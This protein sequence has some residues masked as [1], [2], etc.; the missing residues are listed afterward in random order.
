MS[1]VSSLEEMN[2]VIHDRDHITESNLPI[3]MRNKIAN[4]RSDAAHGASE[5]LNSEEQ[6]QNLLL[7]PNETEGDATMY[8]SFYHRRYIWP[9]TP[10][11]LQER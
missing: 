9:T 1:T 2:K 8:A 4:W 7:P 6:R 11:V 5:Q 10:T 3:R